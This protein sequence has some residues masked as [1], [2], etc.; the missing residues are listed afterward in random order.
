MTNLTTFDQIM[1]GLSIALGLAAV[2][3]FTVLAVRESERGR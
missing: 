3:I 2:V 1:F